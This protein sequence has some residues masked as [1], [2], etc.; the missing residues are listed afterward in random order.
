MLS[1]ERPRFSI[2]DI[3]LIVGFTAAFVAQYLALN[4]ADKS[5]E[6]RIAAVEKVAHGDSV[7][8]LSHRITRMEYILCATDDR[9]RALACE[10][11]GVLQ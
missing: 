6:A 3:G 11:M 5:F 7:A 4:Q 10:R 9:A 1:D 8:A 2:K